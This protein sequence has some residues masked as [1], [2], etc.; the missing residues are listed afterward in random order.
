VQFDFEG[1]LETL[2]PLHRLA[3]LEA[4]PPGWFQMPQQRQRLVHRLVDLDGSLC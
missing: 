4:L 3:Q 1:F 2:D